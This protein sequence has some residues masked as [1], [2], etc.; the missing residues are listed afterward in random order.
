LPT[1]TI[2]NKSEAQNPKSETKPNDQNSNVSN[3]KCVQNCK[4]VFVIDNL[5]FE[6]V[7]NFELRISLFYGLCM[8]RLEK[9]FKMVFQIL[10]GFFKPS[11]QI[12]R[13]IGHY[14]AAQGM[15]F[16]AQLFDVLAPEFKQV[17][18]LR[19]A[20]GKTVLIGRHQSRYP[21]AASYISD[22]GYRQFKIII[23]SGKQFNG[24]VFKRIEPV[25]PVAL[26][27]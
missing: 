15:I 20:A 9:R 1:D 18:V 23:N 13:Q 11:E 19:T 6:F 26:A 27:K 4:Y 8:C 2:D 12:L 25:G 16:R 3:R 10:S 5:I 21:E 24:A 7:S 22:D 14:R 17:G